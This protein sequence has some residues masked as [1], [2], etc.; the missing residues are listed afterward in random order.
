MPLYEYKNAETG[1]IVEY[2]SSF[3]DRPDSLFDQET[4]EEFKLMI[5]RPNLMASNLS[6]WQRG[7][8]SF[9]EYDRNLNTVV[10]GE[11][12]RDEILQKRNLVRESDLPKHYALDAAEKAAGENERLD[13]ESDKFFAGMKKLGLHKAGDSNPQERL[14]ATEKFWAEQVPSGDV[15][16]NPEKYGVGKNT[17]PKEKSDAT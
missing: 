8:S 5:S 13:R 4:G 15:R 3:K 11:Q 9:G 14:R 1:I 17:K 7:L 16:N 10:Y 12:H 6:D 2:I